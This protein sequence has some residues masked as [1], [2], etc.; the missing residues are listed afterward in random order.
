MVQTDDNQLPKA[1]LQLAFHV[2][3]KP[4]HMV[5]STH[6]QRRQALPIYGVVPAKESCVFSV[7]LKHNCPPRH[8]SNT[9]K[10]WLLM[11]HRE[12]KGEC[13]QNQCWKPGNNIL[14]PYL[15]GIFSFWCSSTIT[16]SLLVHT[17]LSSSII[18]CGST[19]ANDSTKLW[20]KI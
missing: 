11:E 8:F 16:T 17:R 14:F 7:F 4:S 9:V 19:S 12:V 13:H 2:Y 18:S 20:K 10:M 5:H 15:R 1:N 6:Q 3:E